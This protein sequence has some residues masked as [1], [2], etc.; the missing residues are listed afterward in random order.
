MTIKFT[1]LAKIEFDTT[2]AYY[3][4]ESTGLGERFKSEIRT[5]IDL[6]L[7][8]P[9]LY[10]IVSNDI[11]KCVTHTFP[12]TIFY[13]HRKETIYIYAI[14]NHHQKPSHYTSRFQK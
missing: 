5:S 3:E 4:N 6:I 14:A 8:F 12:Y 1:K 7:E 2:I 11:R 13:T 10:P 9:T